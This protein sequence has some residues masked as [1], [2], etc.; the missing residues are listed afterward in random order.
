MGADILSQFELTFDLANSTLCL[1]RDLSYSP[2]TNR[3]VG[4]GIQFVRN[5]T[6]DYTVMG[7]WENSPAALAGISQGDHIIAINGNNVDL[8][9]TDEFWRMLHAD[10]GHC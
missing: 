2:V 4:L 3:F 1:R 9:T 6:G 10:E 8:F 5:P 7:V